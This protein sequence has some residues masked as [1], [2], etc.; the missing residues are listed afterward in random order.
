MDF[1]TK[2][3]NKTEKYI[4]NITSIMIILLTLLISFQVFIRYVLNTGQFWIQELSVITM[5][6]IA[7]LGAA[8]AVW[9][10]SHIGLNFIVES[11]PASIRIWVRVLNDLIILVFSLLFFNYGLILIEKTMGGTLSALGFPI[12]YTYIIIP[13]SSLLMALFSLVK[14]INRIRLFYFNNQGGLN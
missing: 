7:F 12:G 11:F 13:I 5:M 2:L 6:W 3:L 9:D 8:A 10:N 14:I 4:T 1:F